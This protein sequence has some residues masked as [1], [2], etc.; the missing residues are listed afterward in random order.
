M[1]IIAGHLCARKKSLRD[2]T[3]QESVPSAGRTLPNGVRIVTVRSP[4]KLPVSRVTALR[5]VPVGFAPI[6]SL[7]PYLAPTSRTGHDTCTVGP[8]CYGLH[9]EMKL[10]PRL[11][12][13]S[14]FR[15][16]FRE[17]LSSRVRLSGELAGILKLQ[18]VVLL[19]VSLLHD[20]RTGERCLLLTYLLFTYLLTP[21][22]TVLLKKLTGSQLVKK[23]PAFYGNRRFITAFTSARHLYLS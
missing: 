20:G 13:H 3:N 6:V 16:D 7:C 5:E 14:W 17:Q 8:L 1:S 12:D 10:D 18:P 19:H 15:S 9:D 2:L 23:F 11:A 4:F 22:S 21:C